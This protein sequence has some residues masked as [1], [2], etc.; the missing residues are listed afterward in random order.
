M[1]GLGAGE[2]A[3]IGVAA[4]IFI[5]PKKL[6]ELA[7]GLG[8]G[9]REFQKAKDDIKDQI[10]NPPEDIDATNQSPEKSSKI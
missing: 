7:R 2:L 10:D 4:L 8:K 9:I 3:I 6:P 1:F 5:G